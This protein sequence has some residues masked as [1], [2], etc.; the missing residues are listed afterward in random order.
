LGSR[1]L[2]A[3]D[4]RGTGGSGRLRCPGL[5]RAVGPTGDAVAGLERAVAACA[6]RLGAARAH[7]TTTDSVEDIEAVRSALGVDKLVLYGTSYGTKV[8]LDYAAAH[9]EHVSRL[10]LDSTVLPEGVDPFERATIASIPRV[11]RAVCA[12]GACR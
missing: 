11:M 3:F 1:R 10:L 5:G 7:Y 9:P 8:A 4:Q 6:Q 12:D 2:V